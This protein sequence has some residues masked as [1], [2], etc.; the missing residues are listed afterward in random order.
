MFIILTK[1][2]LVKI[3][4]FKYT[5]VWVAGDAAVSAKSILGRTTAGCRRG[6][7]TLPAATDGAMDARDDVPAAA[8]DPAS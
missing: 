5:D 6:S 2:L 1:S 4:F 7:K 8:G 3:N